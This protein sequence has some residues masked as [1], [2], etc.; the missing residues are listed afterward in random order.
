MNS[1]L[2]RYRDAIVLMDKR[3]TKH[4]KPYLVSA[5]GRYKKKPY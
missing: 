4:T 5:R 2:V 3:K 1:L